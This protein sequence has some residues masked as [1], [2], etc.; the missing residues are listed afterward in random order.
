MD[1]EPSRRRV[2]V[3]VLLFDEELD[4]E[5]LRAG[6]GRSSRDWRKIVGRGR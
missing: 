6:P 3:T 5:L 1:A 2:I 4:E